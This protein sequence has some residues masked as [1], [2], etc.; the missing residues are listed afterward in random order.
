MKILYT[1]EG[2]SSEKSFCV[3]FGDVLGTLASFSHSLYPE[4]IHTQNLNK[5]SIW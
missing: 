1:W 4:Y 5:M 3:S 2:L